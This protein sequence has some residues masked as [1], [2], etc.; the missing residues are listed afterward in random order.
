MADRLQPIL[1]ILDDGLSLY[2]RHFAAFLL[3]AA[4]WF[5]PVAVVAG[6]L[7]ASAQWMTELQVVLVVLGATLLLLPLLVYLVGGLSRA[8][9]AAAEGRPVRL[10]E[11]L[12]IPPRRAAGMGCFTIVYSIV[13]QLVSSALSFT[14]ICPLWIFGAAFVGVLGATG[15]ETALGVA[16][17]ALLGVLFAGVYLF[18]LIVG[19]ASYSSLVYALQP[20]AQ[21]SLPF[22]AAMERSFALIGYRFWRNALAWGLSA[23]LLAAVALTVT[24]AVGLLV[25]LPLILALGEGSPVAQAASATAW[26]IGLVV[27]LPP[28]P[29]W[30]ALL[31]RSNVQARAGGDLEARVHAWVRDNAGAG[32]SL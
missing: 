24:L 17:L 25:P 14:C 28:L 4:S 1:A 11:A 22:G 20:W 2:R 6:L 19:G 16:A 21:E 13:M 26:L 30:M 9:L 23:V 32:S 7:V 18:A 15:G 8:A 3:I 31:Y 5:V 10:R 29:I 12:A 27:V